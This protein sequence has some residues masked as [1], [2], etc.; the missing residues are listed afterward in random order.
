MILDMTLLV[1]Q[2]LR[3]HEE[4]AVYVVVRVINGHYLKMQYGVEKIV[5]F[6]GSQQLLLGST[7][8]ELQFNFDE[9]FLN[10]HK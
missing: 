8:A 10:V 2:F 1:F 3:F 6:C 7:F 9:V 5:Y 4:S